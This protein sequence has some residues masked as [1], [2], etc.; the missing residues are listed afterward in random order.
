MYCGHPY[1]LGLFGI[2]TML[3]TPE[4]L[5]ALSCYVILDIFLKMCLSVSKLVKIGQQ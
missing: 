2:F 5:N 3:T 1:R 4:S